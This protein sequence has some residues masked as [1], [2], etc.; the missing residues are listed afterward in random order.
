LFLFLKF[1][2]SGPE[3]LLKRGPGLDGLFLCFE[4]DLLAA[5]LRSANLI[6]GRF[7]RR[8]GAARHERVSQIETD[9]PSQ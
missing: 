1:L 6:L 7:E 3:F 2:P 8:T 9:G 5:F 4:K